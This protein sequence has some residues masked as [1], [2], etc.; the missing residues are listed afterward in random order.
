MVLRSG[1]EEHKGN[2]KEEQT[3]ADFLALTK[4]F[5]VNYAVLSAVTDVG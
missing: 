3:A 2:T 5:M 4:L 1:E